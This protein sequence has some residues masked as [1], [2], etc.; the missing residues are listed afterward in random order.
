MTD[1]PRPFDP[2]DPFLRGFEAEGG[3]TT[4]RDGR[5]LSLSVLSAFCLPLFSAG[6]RFVAVESAK[7]GR[8]VA[9]D[10][11]A[12]LAE[13]ERERAFGV[14]VVELSLDWDGRMREAEGEGRIPL[15]E[16]VCGVSRRV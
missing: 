11:L 13:F 8:A 12:L 15:D 16:A 14:A 10:E 3:F 7:G 2:F 6:K 5:V 1:L 9:S 4:I